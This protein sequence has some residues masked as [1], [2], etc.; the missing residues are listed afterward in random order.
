MALV[1]ASARFSKEWMIFGGAHGLDFCLCLCHHGLD[2][3]PLSS[4]A[5]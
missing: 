3:C 1:S 4:L 5:F 2:K